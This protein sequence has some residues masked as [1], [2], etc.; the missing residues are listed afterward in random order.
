MKMRLETLQGED[1]FVAIMRGPILM[2]ASVGTEIWTDW[3]RMMAVGDTIWLRV[4][5]FR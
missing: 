3:L 5:W 4:S 1:D 2:G